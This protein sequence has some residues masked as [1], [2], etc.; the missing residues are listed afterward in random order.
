MNEQEKFL[1]ELDN[2]ANP[3]VDILEAPLDADAPK[4]DAVTAEDE[5]NVSEEVKN[6]RHRRLESK[7]QAERE[8]NIQ[9]AAKLEANTEAMKF[10]QGNSNGS[11]FLNGIDKIYGTDSSEAIAATEL[12]KKAFIDVKEVAKNEALEILR[13][14]QQ[15]MREAVDNELKVL[16]SMVEDIED[17]YGV[18]LTSEKGQEIKKGYLKAIERLSP[19][20]SEGRILN[21]ADHHAV[22]EDFQVKLN[23]RT[24]NR[25]K[26][27]SARSM[28]HSNSADSA[29]LGDDAATKFLRENGIL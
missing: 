19:K 2:S 18:D 21:Y 27:I 9:M 26:D 12:L 3:L 1:K 14:E 7:L 24:E 25:A 15:V 11:E 13:S 22:W 4:V 5:E 6:R 29:K 17:E 20:D 10:L 16:D 23:K 8:A 28:V